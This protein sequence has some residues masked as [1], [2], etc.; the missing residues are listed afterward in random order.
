[1][2]YSLDSRGTFKTLSV[3]VAL[4]VCPALLLLMLRLPLGAALTTGWIASVVWA[5]ASG[6][7]SG[8]NWRREHYQARLAEIQADFNARLGLDRIEVWLHTPDGLSVRDLTPTDINGLPLMGAEAVRAELVRAGQLLM[9][10]D[11]WGYNTHTVTNE[12]SQRSRVTFE[13]LR[14]RWVEAKLLHPPRQG[15]ALEF[16]HLGLKTIEQASSESL[17][18]TLFAGGSDKVATK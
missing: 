10:G 11:T 4:L 6:F 7:L 16:T 17:C 8:M 3:A 18:F 15:A 2:Q 5:A 12:H 9:R 14:D 13:A 1:M